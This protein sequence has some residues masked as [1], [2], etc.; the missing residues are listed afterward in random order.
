[1]TEHSSVLVV[2]G[3]T[4]GHV[5]PGLAVAHA[6]V[7][8]GLDRE[9]VQ[10]V[11]AAR[12][13]EATLV[14]DAGFEIDLLPGRGI[15]RRL[16]LE[17]LGAI[18]GLVRAMVQ[19]FG[20]VR[21][22][23]PSVVVSVGGY[24]SVGPSLAAVFFRRPL[25]V[26]EQNAVAGAANRIFGRF[27][28]FCAVP[29]EQTDLPKSRVTGNPVRPEIA[30]RADRRDRGTARQEFG[31]GEGRTVVAVFAGSLGARSI[32][33]AVAEWAQRWR[34][35]DDLHVHHVLGRRDFDAFDPPDL[36]G[37]ALEYTAVGFE[38][39]MDALLAATD[40]AV[41]RSGGT[42]VAELAVV[43]VPAVFVPFPRAP[44]DH[45]TVNA[46]ALVAAGAAIIVPD[47]QLD[48]DRLESEISTL[49]SGELSAEDQLTEMAELAHSLGRPHAAETIAGLILEVMDERGAEHG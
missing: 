2:G 16:T 21:R 19:S 34:D 4:G 24:A 26:L 5:I 20:L 43:G 22:R 42:T 3:G 10:F 17:N 6:L 32:N 48:A 14:P 30:A 12:G 31:V 37:A 15:Q 13:I 36:D 9:Q 46:A 44:R 8:N 33:G 18:W 45:Q 27:A 35:R 41:C 1:V 49:L 23:R 40:L 7:A 38:D 47:D 11:G 29:F 39:H 28:R 25:V